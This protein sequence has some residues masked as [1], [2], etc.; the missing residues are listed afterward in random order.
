MSDYVDFEWGNA[1][2]GDTDIFDCCNA[3]GDANL[4]ILTQSLKVSQHI[5]DCIY[6][7]VPMSTVY[8]IKPG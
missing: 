5:H 8:I 2:N 6:N 3:N 7:K 4:C 1:C